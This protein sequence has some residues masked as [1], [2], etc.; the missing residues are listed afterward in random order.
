VLEHFSK[1]LAFTLALFCSSI[2]LNAWRSP[3]PFFAQ[4]FSKSLSDGSER[5]LLTE[6]F[7]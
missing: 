2:F 7:R 6:I 4:A 3:S 5:L 1:S